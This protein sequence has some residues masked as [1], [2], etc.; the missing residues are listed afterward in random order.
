M[1]PPDH[2]SGASRSPGVVAEAEL[3]VGICSATGPDRSLSEEGCL[4]LAPA[5]QGF[6]AH[7]FAVADGLTWPDAGVA[8]A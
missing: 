6:A 7:L 4:A 8:A 5:E 2:R 1:T 3:D